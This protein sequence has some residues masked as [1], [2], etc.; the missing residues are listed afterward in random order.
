MS[1]YA[2]FRCKLCGKVFKTKLAWIRY[3][4]VSSCG[5]VKG[6][7]SFAAS[8]IGHFIES[9]GLE[10]FYGKNEKKF[11]IYKADIYVPSCDLVI[12]YNGIRYHSKNPKDDLE[13]FNYIKD[14]HNIIVIYEDEWLKRKNC[15][16]RL[17]LNK[18]GINKPKFRIRPQKCVIKLLD[19]KEVKEF[20][21]KYHY[22]G[23]ANS[24]YNIGVFYNDRLVACM[25]IKSPTRQNSG[26][27][28]ISRMACH[29]DYR[30][31]GLWSYLLKWV[32]LNNLISGR[33]I[34]FSDNRL[35][36]GDVYE[37]MGMNRDG[38]INPDYY[39]VRGRNRYHKSGL[40]KTKEEKLSGKTERQL[41]EEQGY[42]RIFDL[43]KV[44]WVLDLCPLSI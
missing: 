40:R 23:H 30:I 26:D 37:K 39:W 38:E 16:K 43:G 17:V 8:E 2:K 7:F 34:T 6:N 27:W 11:D 18:L 13:K 36:T 29:W 28:E 5:C 41:R 19:N 21:E 35:M 33:I 9:E 15:F 20:Y 10:A 42:F 44:K 12:E 25:S 14:K 24:K 1:V 22:Q 31:F 3:S 32:R 4:R